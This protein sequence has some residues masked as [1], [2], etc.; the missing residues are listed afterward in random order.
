[1][2]RLVCRFALFALVL[3]LFGC[4]TRTSPPPATPP[5]PAATVKAG[6]LLQEYATNAVAAD[7]KYKGQFIQVSGK[8]GTAQKAPLF[9]YAVQL[10]P[11]DAGDFTASSVQCFILEAAKEDV[12]NLQP[13]QMISLQGTCDGQVIGQVKLSKCTLV[14]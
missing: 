3:C 2:I 1:M 8:F 5:T 11:E 7:A 12:A 4:K 14:K 10:L 6:A 13:G 9:G